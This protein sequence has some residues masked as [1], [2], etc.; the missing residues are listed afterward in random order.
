MPTTQQ[1]PRTV[2]VQGYTLT[3]SDW[4]DENS[5]VLIHWDE[6]EGTSP[7]GARCRVARVRNPEPGTEGEFY[8]QLGDD[9]SLE[10]VTIQDVAELLVVMLRL[11]REFGP[12]ERVES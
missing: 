2:K 12:Q 4:V 9:T 11:E 8:V 10:A 5:D 6:A 3:L 7:A 1:K